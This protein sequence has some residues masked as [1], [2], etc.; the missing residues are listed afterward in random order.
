MLTWA[1][2]GSD[3]KCARAQYAELVFL[4]SVGFAG[5]VVQS[6]ASGARNVK[7]LFFMLEWLVQ[8]AQNAS[9]DT[10]TE[11]V[12]LDSVGSAGHVLHWRCIRGMKRQHTIFHAR[13]GLVQFPQ[14]AHQETLRRPCVFTSGGI[15][16]SLSAFWC[17]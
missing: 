12:F 11:L 16:G 14:N 1:F 2:Y 4:H 3:E 17:I 13:I 5:H 7:T 8:M 15:Y 10:Y 9:L 6:V